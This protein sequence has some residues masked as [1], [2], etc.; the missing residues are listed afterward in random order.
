[1]K[2]PPLARLYIRPDGR[3]L[4][5]RHEVNDLLS[6]TGKHLRYPSAEFQNQTEE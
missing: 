1:M 4:D 5:I 2:S 3:I 6:Q